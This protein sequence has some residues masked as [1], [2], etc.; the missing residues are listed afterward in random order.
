[1]KIKKCIITIGGLGSRMLPIT[2]TITKEML[3]IIDVPA[4]FL[5]ALLS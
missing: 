1:M 2:K 5:K 3:P 4:I